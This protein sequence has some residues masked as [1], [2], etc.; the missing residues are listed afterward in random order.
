M[1]ANRKKKKEEKPDK[2]TDK[3]VEVKP[4]VNF[5]NIMGQSTNVPVVILWRQKALFSFTNKNRPN[6]TSAHG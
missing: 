3:E 2:E 4:G 6:W 5:I 1:P